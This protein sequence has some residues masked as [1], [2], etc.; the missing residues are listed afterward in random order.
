MNT[1]TERTIAIQQRTIIGL[2][3]YLRI[4]IFIQNNKYKV[5]QWILTSSDYKINIFSQ[6]LPL[7]VSVWCT[8]HK[9]CVV[10][11]NK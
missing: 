11:D 6:V 1:E 10:I 5:V 9:Y 4:A 2:F 7:C 3:L 8:A